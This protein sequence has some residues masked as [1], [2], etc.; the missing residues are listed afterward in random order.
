VAVQIQLSPA[1]SPRFLMFCREMR[2]ISRVRGGSTLHTG[3]E[4]AKYLARAPWLTLT[5]AGRRE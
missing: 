1:T 2:E 4:R 3:P 5:L